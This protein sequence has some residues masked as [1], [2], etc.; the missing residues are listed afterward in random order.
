MSADAVPLS[1][2]PPTILVVEDDPS[3]GATLVRG[4][5]GAGFQVQL[6]TTGELAMQVVAHEQVDLVLLDLN[7]PDLPG[8][9]V[10]DALRTRYTAP[11]IVLTARTELRDRL[12]AFDLGAVDYLAKPFWMEELVARIRVRL[13]VPEA[14]ARQTFCWDEVS[15]DLEG[16]SVHMR[17]D[18]VELTAHEFNVL[19]LFVSKRGV[20]LTREQIATAAL[21]YE[22]ERQERTVDSHVSRIRKK[23][24]SA[25]AKIRTV[26]GIGYRFE[27]ERAS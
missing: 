18:P 26:W 9:D 13:K 27:P 14:E 24:G 7:L 23:L 25:G 22:G 1:A 8:F 3:I 20:A 17:G 19:A 4:L 15:V 21:P 5:R 11:V 10:L 6:A 2:P 12:R 16:R